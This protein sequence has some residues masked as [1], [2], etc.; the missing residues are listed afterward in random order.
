MSTSSVFLAGARSA[1]RQA[2]RHAA[3]ADARRGLHPEVIESLADAGF[4]RRF[5]PE[6]FGGEPVTFAELTEAVSAVGEGCASA[7]W[8]ASLTAYNG[9]FATFLPHEGQKEVWAHG[10]DTRFAAGLVPHGSAD[11]VPGG[12]RI[13]GTWSYVSG[14][15]IAD[16]ILLLIPASADGAQP[17]RFVAV[18]AAECTVNST[19]FTFGMRGTASHSLTCEDVFVPGHRSFLAD[20]MFAGRNQVSDVASSNL[21][22]FAVAGLT[23]GAPVMGAARAAVGLAAESLAGVPGRPAKEAQRLSFARAAA[24]VD[25][26]SLLMTRMATTADGGIPDALTVARS[27]RDGAYAAQ[28]FHGAVDQLFRGTGMRGQSDGDPLQRIWRDVQGAVRHGGLLFEP[29]AL[30]YTQSLASDG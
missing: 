1:A 10:P 25:A 18:E 16:W 19:W 9:R 4:A 8:I 11:A 12:W 22:L 14:A 2:A 5:V 29:A 7:A 6:H 15:E 13:S 30:A 26:A 3:H 21:P 20:D 27:R 23:F 28:M 17:A 24:E